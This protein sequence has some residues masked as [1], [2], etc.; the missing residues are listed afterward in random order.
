MQSYD[1]G[2]AGETQNGSATSKLDPEDFDALQAELVELARNLDRRTG[3][4][5]AREYELLVSSDDDRRNKF[6]M[7]G[8]DL[9]K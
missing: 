7:P 1:V 2:K 5:W 6:T 8:G 4:G 3:R 9:P